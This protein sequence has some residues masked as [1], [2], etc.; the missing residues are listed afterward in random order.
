[1]KLGYYPGCS[2]HS[3]GI[4]YDM[5]TR[6]TAK[7]LGIELEEIE[8]W[9]CC[10]SS[11]AHS[12]DEAMSVALPAKNMTLLKEENGLTEVCVPCASC[13]SRLKAAQVRLKDPRQRAEVEEIIGGRCPDGINV[14]HMLDAVIQKVGVENVRARVVRSL[15][16]LKVAC[17]YGCLMTRPPK[18]TGKKDYENPVE[19]EAL[20]EAAGAKPVDWNGKTWCCGA[21]FA[22]TD[23]DVVLS[24]TRRLLADAV[25]AGAE[26]V[27]VGCPLCHSNL[28]ARQEQ[29]N[30]KFDT[31]FRIPVFYFTELLGLALGAAPKVLGLDKHI[32][33][34]DEFLERRG[35]SK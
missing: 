11:P 30:A 3:T 5:S 1:M 35:W 19:M 13:Y 14:M 17:Y 10:G 6:E 24:M 18:V 4:E 27:A 22:L 21:S 33:E 2:L 12:R 32:T 23:T 28:D 7:R 15:A 34:V 25:A 20:L 8:G 9:V 16:G 29:I 31:D 26:A